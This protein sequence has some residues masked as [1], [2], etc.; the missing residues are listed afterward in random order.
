MDRLRRVQET[1]KRM[2]LREEWCISADEK[3]GQVWLRGLLVNQPDA[4]GWLTRATIIQYAVSIEEEPERIA[5]E[6][7]DL[8]S[9]LLQHEVDEWVCLDGK[10]VVEPHPGRAPSDGGASGP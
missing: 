8:F 9:K 1:L 3:D 5:Q 2:S 4:E 6:V 7:H 10:P